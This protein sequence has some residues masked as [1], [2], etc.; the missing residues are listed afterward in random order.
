MAGRWNPAE[1]FLEQR[2]S[3]YQHQ[4]CGPLLAGSQWLVLLVP[5][6]VSRASWQVRAVAFSGDHR[7]PFYVVY[8]RPSV[9]CPLTGLEAL[10]PPHH[11]ITQGRENC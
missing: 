2:P 9:G 10:G 5:L 7:S 4:F 11:G 8:R 1:V 3:L 6:Q